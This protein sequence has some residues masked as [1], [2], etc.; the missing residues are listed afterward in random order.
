[1]PN[2]CGVSISR[3][4]AG[5]PF[6]WSDVLNS[7]LRFKSLH[8]V[9]RYYDV[10]GSDHVRKAWVHMT[11]HGLSCH[12]R[13]ATQDPGPIMHKACDRCDNSCLG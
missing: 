3:I 1:M 12:G 13:C 8:T 7:F 9:G 2:K 10:K 4:F 5:P 6:V 11:A